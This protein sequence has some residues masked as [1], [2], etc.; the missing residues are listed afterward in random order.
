M[1]NY[2]KSAFISTLV[3]FLSISQS[4]VSAKQF[5]T[6]K[7]D[8]VRILAIGNSFSEDALEYYFYGLAKAGGHVV[9]VGNL[10]IGGAPLDLHWK[11]AHENNSAYDYRKIGVDGVKHNTPKISLEKAIKDEKWDYIS[12]QQASPKSGLFETYVEP[13][14]KLFDYIKATS[15]NPKVKMVFHQTWA[16]AKNSTHEGFLSYHK[17]QSEMYQS[18]MSA[19]KKAIKLKPFDLLVPNGAA[20][21]NARTSS[22]GDN[23]NRDGYHLNLDYGRYTASCTWYEIIFKQSVIGNTYVPANVGAEKASI[24]Q[25]SAHAAAKKPFKITTIN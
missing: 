18:I 1:R 8:T 12:L 19:S 11:N 21:Q 2:F 5:T 7:T 25:K 13:L 4:D 23:M 17:D 10:Y 20:V 15:T 22:I 9:I 24:A 6:F 16:Y 14:P 3:L